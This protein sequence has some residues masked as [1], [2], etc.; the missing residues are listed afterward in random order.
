MSTLGQFSCGAAE[1]H[2]VSRRRTADGE[3]VQ[4]WHSG[5]LTGRFG[6]PPRVKPASGPVARAAR[7][8]AWR[9]IELYDSSELAEHIARSERLVREEAEGSAGVLIS[10]GLTPPAR[11]ARLV[12][13]RRPSRR[14]K[15]ST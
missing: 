14:G 7:R 1:D 9:T 6:Y 13:R 12:T 4:L 8:R 10:L 15:E 11:A 2:V 5:D 3:P